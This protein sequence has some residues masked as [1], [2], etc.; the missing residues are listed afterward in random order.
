MT[1]PSE[2][3]PFS[4]L[5]HEERRFPPLP[6][7]A[8][9]AHIQQLA[10]YETLYR[11]SIEEND[12]FWLEQAKTLQWVRFPTVAASYVWEPTKVEHTWF[13]DGQLNVCSNCLDRHLS[14]KIAI[15][16]QGEEDDQVRKFTYRDLHQEVGRAANALRSLGVRRGDRI[17][18]YLPMIPEAAIAMLACAR[19]GAIHSVVFGGFSSDPNSPHQ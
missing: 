19:I 7:I 17:C 3:S 4:H 15:I 5:L 12:S 14:D 8:A 16:W 10:D 9:K 6:D 18:I 2:P 11:R 13:A 1:N